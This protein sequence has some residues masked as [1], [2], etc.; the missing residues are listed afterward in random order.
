MVIK[1]HIQEKKM[2]TWNVNI[3]AKKRKF[4]FEDNIHVWLNTVTKVLTDNSSFFTRF[5]IIDEKLDLR[6]RPAENWL[7]KSSLNVFG[8]QIWTRPALMYLDKS[9]SET[10]PAETSRVIPNSRQHYYQPNKKDT[11]KHATVRD[12]KALQMI[13]YI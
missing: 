3:E 12:F 6:P 7:D 1:N 13:W 4:I 5:F 8:P 11:C 10:S 9:S 2:Q